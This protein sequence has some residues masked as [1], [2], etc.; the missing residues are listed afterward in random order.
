MAWHRHG[1]V[2][3]DLRPRLQLVFSLFILQ[4]RVSVLR[5]VRRQHRDSADRGL[6]HDVELDGRRIRASQIIIMKYVDRHVRL[7]G[8]DPN[9]IVAGCDQRCIICNGRWEDCN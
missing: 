7:A 5:T 4:A 2:H 1:V 8:A 3:L 9:N 6:A